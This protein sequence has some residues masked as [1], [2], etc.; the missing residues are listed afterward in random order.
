MLPLQALEDEP[1]EHAVADDD[2]HEPDVAEHE[3]GHGAGAGA[4]GG[5][6][7]EEAGNTKKKKKFDDGSLDAT[8]DFEFFFFFFGNKKVSFQQTEMKVSLLSSF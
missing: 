2:G 1:A 6:A 4:E 8:E 5:A 7:P 3:Q